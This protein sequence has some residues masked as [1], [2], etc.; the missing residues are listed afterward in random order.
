MNQT[1]VSRLLAAMTAAVAL[2]AV[3]LLGATPRARGQGPAPRRKVERTD[4]Q[5]R[6]LLTEP[7]YYV[8]RRKGTEPAF[9]GKYLRGHFKGTFRCV[10]CGAELFSSRHKF[11]SGTGWPSFYRPIRDE[12]VET[13]WDY[14]TAEARVEVECVDC[15]AHLGHV[16]RDGPPPTGLRY[17]INSVALTLKPVAA[18][19]KTKTKVKAK[20]QTRARTGTKPAPQPG[21]DPRDKADDGTGQ[22]GKGRG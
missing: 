21:N 8:T 11:D 10:G 17:C 9:S 2:T 13:A 12:V 16:F 4:E 3:V 19:S 22:S 7:Q 18:P 20:N 5:W 1:A 15:G 6:R 14:S